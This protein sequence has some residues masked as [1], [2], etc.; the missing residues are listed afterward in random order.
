MKKILLISLVTVSFMLNGQNLPTSS[1][2]FIE[3]SLSKVDGERVELSEFN[4]ANFSKVWMKNQDA[5]IGYIGD[6]YQRIHIHL[7]SIIKNMDADNEYFVYGKS[8]VKNNVCDFQGKFIITHVRE[9][10]RAEREALYKEALK[11]GDQ[12]AAS[13]FGKARGFILAEYY[14][15]ENPEQKGSGVFKGVIKSHFY[16]EKEVLY[17]DDTNLEYEDKYSNNQFLGV[18]QSYKTGA[19]KPC[20]WGAYRIPE[21]GDL[22]IGVGEFSPNTKYLEQ[23]WDTYYRAYNKSESAAK[24]EEETKWW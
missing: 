4:K 6:N 17:F 19:Q 23:G 18:W 8:K 11:H 14:L 15:Y 7:I 3:E 9:F 16:I 12:E 24:K 21:A 20:N 5:V 13:R 1:M 10:N 2:K 22:D